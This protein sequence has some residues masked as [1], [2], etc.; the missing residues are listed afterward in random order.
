MKTTQ[1]TKP[2][3][4]A[5]YN[6]NHPRFGPVHVVRIRRNSARDMHYYSDNGGKTWFVCY[7]GRRIDVVPTFDIR[8]ADETLLHK[9]D[10]GKK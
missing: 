2:T 6:K 4:Y 9:W 8:S 3:R 5:R 1:K 10:G 7:D